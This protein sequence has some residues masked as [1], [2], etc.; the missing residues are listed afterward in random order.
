MEVAQRPTDPNQVRSHSQHKFTFFSADVVSLSK[1]LDRLHHGY[2]PQD[3][4]S[5]KLRLGVVVRNF[6]F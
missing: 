6:P 5:V 4:A 2:L 3:L 1:K